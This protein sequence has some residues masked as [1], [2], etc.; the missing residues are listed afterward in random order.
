MGFYWDNGKEKGNYHIWDLGFTAQGLGLGLM[1][2]GLRF[3]GLG[4]HKSC[5]VHI[6]SFEQALRLTHTILY[7]PWLAG[8]GFRAF[9]GARLKDYDAC[10]RGH[11]WI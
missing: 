7:L 9:L 8:L 1:A 10:R 4:L 3:T 6:G 2:Q 5:R 11:V